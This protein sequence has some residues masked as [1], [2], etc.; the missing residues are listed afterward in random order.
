MRL[1]EAG[2]DL[3][4]WFEGCSLIAY[5]CPAGV[6]TIGYGSTFPDVKEGD[7][8]TKGEALARLKVDV[9]R[10]ED[11]VSE[12]LGGAAQHE[13]D[14]CVSLAFN[15]GLAAFKR[16]SVLRF[17]KSGDK[18][19]AADA[20]LLWNKAG[21][22]VLVGLKIRREAERAHYLNQKEKP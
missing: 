17:H 15:T 14:A 4:K 16:S 1:S 9:S 18:A 2:I 20:F 6:W 8:I 5:R 21:G 11:G 22:K 12:V 19:K 3:I 13:F 10:F 7:V